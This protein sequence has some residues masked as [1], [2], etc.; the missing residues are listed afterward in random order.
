MRE[1]R[2]RDTTEHSHRGTVDPTRQGIQAPS[3]P[4]DLPPIPTAGPV[5]VEQALAA[6]A[7][8]R[9]QGIPL[10]GLHQVAVALA[11][12]VERLRGADVPQ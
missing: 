5:S 1:N 12:E 2:V 10:F 7:G 4:G 9:A 11:D 6:V 3:T 8:W